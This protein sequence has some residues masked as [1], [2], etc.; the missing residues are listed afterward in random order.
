MLSCPAAGVVSSPKVGFNGYGYPATIS[1]PDGGLL[2]VHGT[3]VTSAW[4]QDNVLTITAKDDTEQTVGTYVVSLSTERPRYIN[5]SMPEAG[6]LSGTFAAVKSVVFAT[7][8]TQV[9]VDNLH[10]T[11]EAAP[12]Q[13]IRQLSLRDLEFYPAP[14]GASA[15]LRK[16]HKA[17]PL[18]EDG[19][20]RA[21]TM[22]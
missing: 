19:S 7:S 22:H 20:K 6:K 12:G 15:A 8:Q 17:S 11:L 3:Y 5:F 18:S 13:N 21:T 1:A 9:A 4:D 10:V 16:P 14:P 2:T